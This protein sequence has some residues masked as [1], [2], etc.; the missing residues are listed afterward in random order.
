MQKQPSLAYLIFSDHGQ[1]ENQ[2]DLHPL[3]LHNSG[4]EPHS[5]S[6]SLM[7]QLHCPLLLE[8]LNAIVNQQ[9]WGWGDETAEGIQAVA[10]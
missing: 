2:A 4:E 7:R 5:K 1:R 10:W 3:Y 6:P 9:H 8:I